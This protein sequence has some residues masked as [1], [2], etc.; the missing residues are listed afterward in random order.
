[1]VQAGMPMT[2]NQIALDA[3]YATPHISFGDD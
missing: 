1:M 3:R 2:V